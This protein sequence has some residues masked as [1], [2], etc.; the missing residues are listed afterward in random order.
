MRCPLFG[1]L[2]AL[3]SCGPPC[4]GGVVC[5]VD[6]GVFYA[7]APADA[8]RDPLPALIFAH[9][10][11]GSPQQYT[12][13]ASVLEAFSAAGVLLIAPEG[14][15]GHWSINEGWG[16]GRDEIAFFD[17]VLAEADEVWGLDADRLY[18][19]GFSVGASVAYMAACERPDLYAAAAP[20][21]GSYWEPFPE[22]CAGGPLPVRHVHGTADQTWPLEGRSFGDHAT[23]GSAQG[24]VDLWRAHDGCAET[25]E[26]V[27]LG[28]LT[29]QVWSDCD[30]DSEVRF[31]LHDEGHT[32][33]D[34]WAA[35]LLEW[36][37][38]QSR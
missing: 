24:A 29:C 8:G 9:G 26:E 23:Q 18:I 11:G 38:L 19:S 34:G 32:R 1:L 13:S 6:D 5:E 15:D 2:L 28:P 37:V 16:S 4:G 14:T 17:E 22:S 33:I 27:V 25:T 21:S 3:V 20:M 12:E 36:L 31:C 10:A 35:D 30:G 7:V